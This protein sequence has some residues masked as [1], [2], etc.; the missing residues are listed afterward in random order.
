MIMKLSQVISKLEEKGLHKTAENVRR[1]MAKDLP[2]EKRRGK[3]KTSF[4]V[5]PRRSGRFKTKYYKE[6]YSIGT[7]FTRDEIENSEISVML[8]SV[9]IGEINPLSLLDELFW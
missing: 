7:D 1:I 8:G 4:R 5:A 3:K 6:L 9:A 2:I